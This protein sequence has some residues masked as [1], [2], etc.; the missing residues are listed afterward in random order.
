MGINPLQI[1]K[2]PEFAPI[3]RGIV[4]EVR[5]PDPNYSGLKKGLGLLGSLLQPSVRVLVGA[6]WSHLLQQSFFVPQKLVIVMAGR[7]T[8]LLLL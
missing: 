7:K 1:Y 8:W 5:A 4:N 2:R 6:R 3:H